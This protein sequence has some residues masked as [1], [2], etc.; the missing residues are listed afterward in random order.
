M[1]TSEMYSSASAME[2]GIS[3]VKTIAYNA[4]V[5]DLT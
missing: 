5:D 4:S 2:N 1:G 3:S